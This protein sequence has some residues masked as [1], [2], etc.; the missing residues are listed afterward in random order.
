MHVKHVSNVIFL[1]SIQRISIK[2]HENTCQYFTLCS[3]TVLSK[4]KAL[5]L[6]KTGLSTIKHQHSKISHHGQKPLQPKT[7]KNAN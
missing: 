4:D 3:F 2:Y 1:S 7:H 5:Q 6:T